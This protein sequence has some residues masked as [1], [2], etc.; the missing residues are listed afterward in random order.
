MLYVLIC[1]CLSLAGIAGLQMAYMFYIDR[2]DRERKKR[3]HEL[4]VRCKRLI[5]RLEHAETRIRE[6][7]EM[8]NTMYLEDEEHWADVIDDR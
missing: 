4:E 1:L 8:I 5:D 3:L 2:L 7:E 6:Q